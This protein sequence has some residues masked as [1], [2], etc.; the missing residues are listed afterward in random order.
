[1]VELCRLIQDEKDSTRF[2]QL[3]EE[4]G[5]LLG[6][7]E[8][9]KSRVHSGKPGRP[10][11]CESGP[12]LFC[13][14]GVSNGVRSRLAASPLDEDLRPATEGCCGCHIAEA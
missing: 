8:R 5:M 7:S 14:P 9:A 13:H 4:L 6:H 3:I 11:W 1:M 2:D 10:G 12:F